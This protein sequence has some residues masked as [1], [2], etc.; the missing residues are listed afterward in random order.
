MNDE[1][2]L[3]K[4]Y[5]LLDESPLKRREISEGAGVGYHWLHKFKQRAIADPGVSQVERLVTF[6]ERDQR[7]NTAPTQGAA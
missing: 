6:L 1:S 5:R 3:A 2:L 7:A 4:A